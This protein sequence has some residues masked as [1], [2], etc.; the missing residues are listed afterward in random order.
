MNKDETKNFSLNENEV[1]QEFEMLQLKG[2][3]NDATPQGGGGCTNGV[4]PGGG[5]GCSN[6]TCELQ[7]EVS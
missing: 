4:C 6:G 5:G 1:I 3:R 7:E 2:G